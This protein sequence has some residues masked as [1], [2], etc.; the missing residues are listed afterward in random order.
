MVVSTLVQ[1]ADWHKVT[2]AGTVTYGD[3]P[4]TALL[5]AG[6]MW[7]ET[8]TGNLFIWYDDG[9]TTQWVQINNAQRAVTSVPAGSI[10]DYAGAV[11]PEGW[12]MCY[13][14]I[15]SRVLYPAL[16]Q[17][18]GI[19]YGAGDG[20]TTFQLP[21]CRGR[22]AAGKDDM[23]GTKANR[24]KNI[25]DGSV[26]GGAGGG[27]AII[28]D[29]TMIPSHSHTG[30]TGNANA[31]HTHA[32]NVNT[33]GENVDH[34]H[35]VGIQSGGVNTNHTHSLTLN[36]RNY[37]ERVGG[38]GGSG[39]NGGGF[40]DVGNTNWNDRDHSHGVNGG[41][42]GRNAGHVHNVAGSTAGASVTHA[43]TITAEGGGLA[44]ANLQ[45]TI[46]FNKIIKV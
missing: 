46:V 26:L 11:A 43:H 5:E 29:L 24:I 10:V 1:M 21:D 34:A 39:T 27:E 8:D 12:M 40:G 36:G 42:A 20:S 6:Q 23:G 22:V 44:H 16:F 17:S 32:F 28:L 9:N 3:K 45:P 2:V 4:P 41:T 31:D 18:I 25:F 7:F 33:G 13:G 14:Q 15:M 30:G 35:S 19:Q 37:I 38:A